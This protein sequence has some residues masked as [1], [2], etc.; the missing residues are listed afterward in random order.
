M[1][2]AQ[3][4]TVAHLSRSSVSAPAPD[5][6]WAVDTEGTL[7]FCNE[8]DIGGSLLA[9]GQVRYTSLLST[10]ILFINSFG[11][12]KYSLIIIIIIIIINVYAH[13]SIYVNV[14]I[15]M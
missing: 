9:W 8:G 15:Y 4:R 3:E 7:W 5:A 11:L 13:F 6:M 1:S 14:N 2:R 10:A 12:L